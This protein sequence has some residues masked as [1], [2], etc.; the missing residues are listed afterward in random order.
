MTLPAQFPLEEASLQ[1]GVSPDLILYFVSC[2]WIRPI[3]GA[4]G[5]YDHEDVA[6]I[7]LIADLRDQ[8]GVNDEAIPV[9]MHL[10]DQI[11][12]FHLGTK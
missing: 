7:E 4:S 5:L 8:M 10:V 3:D 12:R 11:N 2:T 6:R 9:I 1:S